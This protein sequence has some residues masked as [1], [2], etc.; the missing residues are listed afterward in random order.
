[1]KSEM[2]KNACAIGVDVGGTK[3]AA[4]LVQLADGRILARR[5]QPTCPERGGAAV[6]DDVIALIESL[7]TEANQLKTRPTSVG[8]AVCELVSPDG[9]VLSE[10]TVR[11]K[12]RQIADR[13][14]A[15][16]LPVVLDADVRAAARGEAHFG[17]GREFSS[18]LYVTVGT[19]ISACLVLDKKPYAG[20]R[21]LTGTFASSGGL[22]PGG[23]DQLHSGPPLERFAAG[24]ALA[25]RLAGVRPDFRGAAPEVLKL[26]ADGDAIARGIVTSAGTAL[27]AAVAQLVNVLDPEAVV[28]GGGLGLAEGIYRESILQSLRT[29]V[30]SEFHRDIRLISARLGNDAGMVGAAIGTVQT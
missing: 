16:Y 12:D 28:I 13:L 11:W 8:I 6:L 4:G 26:A 3:C 18:F 25:A 5:L 24:P 21:G 19:G 27:G 20:A 10:A 14:A 29:Y 23:D 7:Q 1:M 15:F 30:W 22:I 17:A 2:S 9:Q